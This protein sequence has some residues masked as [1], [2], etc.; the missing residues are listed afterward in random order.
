MQGPNLAPGL[1]KSWPAHVEF[2]S[3]AFSAAACYWEVKEQGAS[4]LCST[5][6]IFGHRL[7]VTE[8]VADYLEPE[9]VIVRNRVPVQ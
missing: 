3:V 7:S 5:A 2:Q 9:S 6:P 4:A 1:D 8:S